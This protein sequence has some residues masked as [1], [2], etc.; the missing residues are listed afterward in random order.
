MSG[1][2]KLQEEL[3]DKILIL[4][5]IE[6]IVSSHKFERMWEHSSKKLIGYIDKLDRDGLALFIKNHPSLER[7]ERPIKSLKLEAQKCGI[8]NYSRMTKAEILSILEYY[9]D[10]KAK[11]ALQRDVADIEGSGVPGE[12]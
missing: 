9:D 7:G 12:L 3:R 8:P 1:R 4:R 2:I 10:E 11:K 5:S 6:L